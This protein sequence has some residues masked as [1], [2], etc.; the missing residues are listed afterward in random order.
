[1]KIIYIEKAFLNLSFPFLV[2]FAFAIGAALAM[3]AHQHGF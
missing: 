1:M 2:L 3:L